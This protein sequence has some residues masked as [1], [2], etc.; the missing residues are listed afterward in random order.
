MRTFLVTST[1]VFFLVFFIMACSRA[2]AP[3][4][5]VP[6][7]PP[8]TVFVPTSSPLDV[9]PISIPLDTLLEEG[10]PLSL[11]INV[12]VEGY[13]RF[14]V[15]SY[16]HSLAGDETFFIEIHR[17]DGSV[18]GATDPTFGNYRVVADSSVY[19]GPVERAAGIFQLLKGKNIVKF[20]KKG[21]GA[22]YLRGLWVEFVGFQ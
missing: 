21:A 13:Y 7:L 9:E 22:L 2:P 10:V 5:P 3:V 4:E 8:D 17:P 1:L 18:R 15:T 16:Y 12:G 19:E 6:S 14:F 11:E 20:F